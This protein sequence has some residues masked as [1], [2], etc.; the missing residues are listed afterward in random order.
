LPG[1]ITAIVCPLSI[2]PPFVLRNS[3]DGNDEVT[4]V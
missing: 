4:P 3:H 1:H 2:R